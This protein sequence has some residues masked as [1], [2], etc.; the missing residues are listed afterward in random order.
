MHKLRILSTTVAIL[1]LSLMMT[2]C[3]SS[4][5]VIRYDKNRTYK[6]T[7]LHTNDNHGR[8]WRNEQGEW[9]MAARKTLIDQ[10]RAE[11]AAEGGKVLLLSGGDVNS[12]VPES[13]LQNA[14]PDF[15]GMNLS[16]YDA[17]V[18]G[19]HEFDNPLSVLH[20]QEDLAD[21]PFLSANTYDAETGRPLFDAFRLFDIGGLSVAV[22]GLT[23]Q[24]TRR[25][26]HPGNVSSV[27]FRNPV[28]VANSLVPLMKEQADIVIALTHLGFYPDRPDGNRSPDDSDLAKQTNG[29]DL[30]VGAHSQTSLYS[31]EKVDDTLILQADEYGKYLGR[32]DFTFQNGQLTLEN[33]ELIPINHKNQ[34]IKIQEDPEM[35]KL[36]KP[37]KKEGQRLAMKTTG[38]SDQRLEGEKNKVR[39]RATNLGV[40]VATSMMEKTYADF[41]VINSG[42]IRASLPAGDISYRDILQVQ[43]YSNFVSYINLTGKEIREYLESVATMPANTGAFAQFAGL[44]MI[45]KGKTVSKIRIQGRPLKEKRKYRMAINDFIA[46]GGDGYPILSNRPEFVST[47]FSGA[48]VL[49]SFIERNSPIKAASYEPV[50]ILRY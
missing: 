30:I 20:Q 12:G 26:G 29:I 48:Y 10:V 6:L 17:M 14:K 22:M 40:L 2:G 37:Y 43:P 15:L 50:G 39:T 16:G 18:V 36:L 13:D 44:Q 47:G 46:A 21:F 33:Y 25:I 1:S 32:A 27:D 49:K 42:G 8:F 9:G 41:A 35:L 19:N 7:I 31:P 11:V 34:S 4:D 3:S 23:T 45:I 5:D 38:H 24:D 28:R